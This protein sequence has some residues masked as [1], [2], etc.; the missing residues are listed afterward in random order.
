MIMI[1]LIII[2]GYIISYFICEKMGLNALTYIGP[3][4]DSDRGFIRAWS[5]LGPLGVL[6]LLLMEGK[7][8]FKEKKYD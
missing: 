3:L 8:C 4:T 7:K 1:W 5:L 6:L 2:M